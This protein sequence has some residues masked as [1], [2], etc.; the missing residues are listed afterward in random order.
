MAVVVGVGAARVDGAQYRH[1]C[2]NTSCSVLSV[3]LVV[4]DHDED[5]VVLVGEVD[6]DAFPAGCHGR[7]DQ[8]VDE[9]L[10]SE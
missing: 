8:A 10:P 6:A 3:G 9:P 4:E 1:L 2:R 5:L 7:V